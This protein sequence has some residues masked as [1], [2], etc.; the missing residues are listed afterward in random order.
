MRGRARAS[1]VPRR[2]AISAFATAI[3]RLVRSGPVIVGS[4]SAS[5]NHF[6]EK[7]S[8]KSTC[9]PP[10]NASATTTRIGTNRKT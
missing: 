10:L 8:H 9:R 1:I 2:H 7:P 6:V 4:W 5:P 3:S